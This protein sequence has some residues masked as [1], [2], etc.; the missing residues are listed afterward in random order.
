MNPPISFPLAVF[1]IKYNLQ[2]RPVT[3]F[4]LISAV[5]R[6]RRQNTKTKSKY[7][8]SFS[9]FL[10]SQKPSKFIYQEIVP[11][12]CE[13]PISCLEKW[14]KD[15]NPPP[16][17][18]INWKVAYQTSFKC[19][20]SCS[21]RNTFTFKLLHRR[22]PTNCFLKNV[23]R[24]DYDKCTFC[25]KETEKLLQLSWRCKKKTKQIGIGLPTFF[26]WT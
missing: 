24:W 18:I 14:R 19:K 2:V 10:M 4:G 23:G 3:F 8:N 9:K 20:N 13:R 25:N 17:E 26:G 22:W 21:K 1:L 11:K 5:N 6:L 16:K 12:N 7:E 15:I